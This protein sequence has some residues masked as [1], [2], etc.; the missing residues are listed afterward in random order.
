MYGN[1]D[2][3][4]LA[5]S[6]L[7]TLFSSI[8]AVVPIQVQDEKG[9]RVNA[10]IYVKTHPGR[11]ELTNGPAIKGVYLL[12]IDAIKNQVAAKEK[13]VI[14]VYPA[15]PEDKKLFRTIAPQYDAVDLVKKK[16]LTITLSKR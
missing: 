13:I 3:T 9:N 16:D 10:M 8:L 11:V 14:F 5:H 15:S 7:F 4:H 1:A 12:D 6:F 2:M